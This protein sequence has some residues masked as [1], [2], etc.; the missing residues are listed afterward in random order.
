MHVLEQH[1]E[2]GL[3]HAELLLH[4]SEVSPILRPTTAPPLPR[5][6]DH[7]LLDRVCR[8]DVVRADQTAYRRNRLPAGG[9]RFDAVGCFTDDG[10]VAVIGFMSGLL[11]VLE[12]DAGAGSY[13]S[14]S[15]GNTGLAISRR[16]LSLRLANPSMMSATIR[17][18]LSVL[19]IVQV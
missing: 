19:R 13:S 11:V 10:D 8:A 7:R 3:V 18:P 15:A 5:D 4:G 16:A 14:T 2:V 17:R 6:A 9:G 12:S 1:T